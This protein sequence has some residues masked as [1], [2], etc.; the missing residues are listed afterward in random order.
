MGLRAVQVAVVRLVLA[1][2]VF[3]VG[4]L[5][6]LHAQEQSPP[7]MTALRIDSSLTLVD[8]IAENKRT[9]L[10]GRELF[11]DLKREDFRILDNGHEMPIASFDIG[12]E[13]GARPVA[14]W[15]IVECNQ[16][17]PPEYHSMFMQGRTQMLK[18]ALAHL[19]ADDVVGVAHWCDNGDAN[20]DTLPG[21]DSDAALAKVEQVLSE[22][23]DRGKHRTGEL[24]M[25][26]M[27]R[28]VLN[29]TRETEPRRLPVFLFLYG[30]H[31][32]THADEANSL[33]K[34]L[35]ETSGMVYGLNDGR[36]PFDPERMIPMDGFGPGAGDIF[37]L[38]HYYSRATG[39]EVHSAADSTQF[40][41][42]LDYIIM[43][44]HDRYTI[45]FK[46]KKLDGKRHALTVELTSAAHK[47]FPA[48]ALRFRSEYIP[49]ANR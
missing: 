29:N 33:A 3:P 35:L 12:A 36:W 34:D 10:R 23:P 9:G 41:A 25:Q 26:R 19:A 49:V 38:V 22:R 14:L 24:A 27:V 44:L 18:P 15:L 47:R 1:G 4:M 6:V 16:G 17:E 7:E 43:Q 30:D 48:V 31:S 46:P 8:V 13:H 21:V 42:A 20:L 39:G 40:S 37:Y 11:S 2:L 45:G 5:A 32:A 28:L